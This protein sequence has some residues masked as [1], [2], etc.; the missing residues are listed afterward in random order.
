MRPHYFFLKIKSCI[1]SVYINDR[2]I[3]YNI[4]SDLNKKRLL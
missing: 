3:I 4:L 1:K 2:I